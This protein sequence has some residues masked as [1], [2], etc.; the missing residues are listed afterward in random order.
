MVIALPND[1]NPVEQHKEIKANLGI[2]E[3]IIKSE[4]H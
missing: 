1:N 2:Q 3:N 4:L